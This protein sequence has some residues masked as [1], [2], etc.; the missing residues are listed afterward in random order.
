MYKSVSPP[1]NSALQ[2]CRSVALAYRSARPLASYKRSR[3][4]A[5]AVAT[6]L[7]AVR[8]TR[9]G[10]CRRPKRP[11]DAPQGRGYSSVPVL[12][13]EVRRFHCRALGVVVANR[14]IKWCSRWCRSGLALVRIRKTRAHT[15]NWEQFFEIINDQT[16]AWQVSEAQGSGACQATTNKSVFRR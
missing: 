3:K 8:N 6:A 14:R 10:K 11:D 5:R 12:A 2:R 1:Y 15:R 13:S 4:S 7:C 9:F 16:V